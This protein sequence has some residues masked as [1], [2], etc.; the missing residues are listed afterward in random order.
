MSYELD[1]DTNIKRNVNHHLVA[2]QNKT[3]QYHIIFIAAT[4]RAAGATAA[5]AIAA[6]NNEKS[7]PKCKTYRLFELLPMYS[8]QL[9]LSACALCGID[10]KEI[11]R[12]TLNFENKK[13]NNNEKM[14][15]IYAGY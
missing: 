1:T 11:D 9:A 2:K 14:T 6:A 10:R 5:V 3:K 8:L 7:L 12:C 4:V 15:L 13:N